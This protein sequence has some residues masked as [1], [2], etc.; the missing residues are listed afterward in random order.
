[1]MGRERPFRG[2]SMPFSLQGRGTHELI[3]SV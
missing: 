2:G 3:V 1:M